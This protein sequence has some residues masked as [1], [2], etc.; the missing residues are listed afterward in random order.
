MIISGISCLVGVVPSCSNSESV[1]ISVAEF[2]TLSDSDEVSSDATCWK[3]S[4]DEVPQTTGMRRGKIRQR[5]WK[6][7]AATLKFEVNHHFGIS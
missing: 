3:R 6:R 7:N 2:S 5:T 1:S 4:S